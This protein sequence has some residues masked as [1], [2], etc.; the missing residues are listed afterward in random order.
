MTQCKGSSSNRLPQV[1][2]TSLVRNGSSLVELSR[3]ARRPSKTL[4]L[5]RLPAST[6]WGPL[7]V[8]SMAASS[9]APYEQNLDGPV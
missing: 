7:S 8:L 3:M 9:C 4:L 1:V 2:L 5:R 6:R